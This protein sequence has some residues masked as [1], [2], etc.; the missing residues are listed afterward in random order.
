M[1][2]AMSNFTIL[3][4]IR[5]ICLSDWPII[6]DIFVKMLLAIHKAMSKV[7]LDEKFISLEY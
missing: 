1:Q 5:A 3:T 4:I 6:C 7:L 2:T